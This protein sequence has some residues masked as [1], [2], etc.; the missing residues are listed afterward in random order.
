M[1][2]DNL[3]KIEE[4]YLVD[5]NGQTYKLKDVQKNIGLISPLFDKV[6]TYENCTVQILS[7]SVTGEMS[8]GWYR[9]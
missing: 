1:G 9:N 3:K 4:L 6:E 2:E 7:N 5:A 8:I